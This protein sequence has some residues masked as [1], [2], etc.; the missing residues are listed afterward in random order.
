VTPGK[1]D[2]ETI[3]DY[4]LV[5]FEKSQKRPRSSLLE[6]SKENIPPESTDQRSVRNLSISFNEK[7]R[8]SLK[9][10]PNARDLLSTIEQQE[11]EVFNLNMVI[12]SLNAK[13]TQKDG[14]ISA[15]IL[16]FQQLSRD[17]NLF[18]R[19]QANLLAKIDLYEKKFDLFERKVEEQVCGSA[20]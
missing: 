17:L 16:E 18:E 4:R 9:M 2:T 5:S 8:P 13:L 10:T 15:Q 7:A 6:N 19:D 14:I 3:S 20:E 1:L 11:N 12:E